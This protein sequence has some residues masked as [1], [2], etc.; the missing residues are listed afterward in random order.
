MK[1]SAG[2]SRGSEPTPELLNNY[3]TP[4]DKALVAS[5]SHNPI[6]MI[7]RPLYMKATPPRVTIPN[8]A[9]AGGGSVRDFVK[10]KVVGTTIKAS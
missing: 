1:S 10:P 6:N 9:E 7:K 4:K 3:S 5:E 8:R 2:S